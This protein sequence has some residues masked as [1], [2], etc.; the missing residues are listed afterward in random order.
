MNKRKVNLYPDLPYRAVLVQV[1]APAA[2]RGC[3]YLLNL[4][5]F[6]SHSQIRYFLSSMHVTTRSKDPVLLVS[7]VVRT[8]SELYRHLII[9]D[10]M[11]RSNRV[12]KLTLRGEAHC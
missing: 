2:R 1:P 5:V 10:L 6:V 3:I 12:Y 8:R 7:G 11:C 4:M 9:A